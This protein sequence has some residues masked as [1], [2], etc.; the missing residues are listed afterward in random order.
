MQ[1]VRKESKWH[2][3]P[4]KEVRLSSSG[5]SNKSNVEHQYD[6]RGI[7]AKYLELHCKKSLPESQTNENLLCGSPA[8]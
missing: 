8:S 1:Y 3:K 6:H 2:T 5:A 7:S 4:D